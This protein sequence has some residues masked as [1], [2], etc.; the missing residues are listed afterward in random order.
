MKNK[1]MVCRVQT[2]AILVTVPIELNGEDLQCVF[3]TRKDE[4]ARV[5]I[6]DAKPRDVG[7]FWILESYTRRIVPAEA[8]RDARQRAF[9][10]LADFEPQTDP[11]T[12]FAF[13]ADLATGQAVCNGGE[14]A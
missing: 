3:I 14:H 13:V 8:I 1:T 2:G 12:S 4:L 10:A 6:F 11:M 7:P 9:D 5:G